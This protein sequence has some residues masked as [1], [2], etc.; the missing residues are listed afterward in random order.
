MYHVSELQ[1]AL[2][3][4]DEAMAVYCKIAALMIGQSKL[5]F[6]FFVAENNSTPDA[7]ADSKKSDE[8]GTT[9][10]IFPR[11]A[12]L[13]VQWNKYDFLMKLVHRSIVKARHEKQCE[14]RN[15]NS[16]CFFKAS[17]RTSPK[18]LF[19]CLLSVVICII[20]LD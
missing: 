3:I 19:R 12:V 20:E 14:T 8:S 17:E 5:N 7:K 10:K 6:R 4:I 2:S 13:F 16:G 11:F 9:E 15:G 1:Q 18:K